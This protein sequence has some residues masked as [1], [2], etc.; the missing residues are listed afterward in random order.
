MG[1]MNRR[2]FVKVMG[3]G[4]ASLAM[5]RP[6]HAGTRG[7]RPNIVFIF[8]DDWGWGDLRCYGNRR[9]RTP[10]IDRMAREGLLFK[11]FYVSAAVCSPSRASILTGLF[12]D[13]H[14]IH[15]H[16]D[17]T[18]A[19]R[20]RGLP[21]YLDPNL[22][23]LPR[24]LKEAGYAT[25]LY[26]KWHL[27]STDYE[28]APTPDK[29]GFNDHRVTVGS[30]SAVH[31]MPGV[32]PG[33]NIWQGSREGPDW[34]KFRARASEMIIDQSIAFIEKNKDRPFYVNAWLYDTHAV[35][36]PNEQQREPFKDWPSTYQTYYSAVH[37]S[38]RHIGRLLNKL[39]ELGLADNTIVI[40]SS[41]N[42]PEEIWLEEA[43]EF[44]VGDPGPF[45]GR[46][47]SGYEGGVRMPFIV[48]W[49]KGTPAGKVDETTV[50]SGADFLPTMCALA[51][52][53]A[54]PENQID[55]LDMSEALR[56]RPMER[57][58]PLFWDLGED[59]IGPAINVSPKVIVRDGKWKL[60]MHADGSGIELYDIAANPLEVDNLADTHPQVVERLVRLLNE[61]RKRYGNRAN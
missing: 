14:G 23:M 8:A 5:S 25:A 52:V 31:E 4:A 41:D 26:G 6:A 53:K 10:N 54:P 39:D 18:R 42:G 60:M 24:I 46:K 55:G 51:G 12:T 30:G 16:L 22:P 38:D 28:E 1:R 40:F 36:V 43:S 47:R 50:L 35:L 49:P 17:S 3:M 29:Y 11:Q 37:D 33:W 32:V 9:I 2:D 15:S 57:T 20:R 7:K 34:H 45:R 27:T 13:R 56:G 59:V 61:R 58:K 48:R 19:N 44:G 21:L